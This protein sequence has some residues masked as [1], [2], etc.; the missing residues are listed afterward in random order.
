M[1]RCP[2]CDKPLR[3]CCYTCPNGA[4][5]DG[6]EGL[7]DV[8]AMQETIESARDRAAVAIGSLADTTNERAERI[9][10]WFQANPEVLRAL[11]ADQPDDEEE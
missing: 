4:H 7:P 10:D 8:E 6:C 2:T 9:L 3:R 11:T 5:D 1:N